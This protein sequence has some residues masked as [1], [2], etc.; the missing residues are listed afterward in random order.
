MKVEDSS[1]REDMAGYLMESWQDDPSEGILASAMRAM[2]PFGYAQPYPDGSYLVP[3]D[4]PFRG[5][6]QVEEGLA[7]IEHAEYARADSDTDEEV[8]RPDTIH[9][10]ALQISTYHVKPGSQLSYSLCQRLHFQLPLTTRGLRNSM[11]EMQ[12]NCVL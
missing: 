8:G 5:I 3:P 12:R 7:E 11:S 6:Y 4:G 9:S 10:Y 2:F 1:S